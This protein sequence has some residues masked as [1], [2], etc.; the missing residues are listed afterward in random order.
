MPRESYDRVI[1]LFPKGKTANLYV[2]SKYTSNALFMD[3]QRCI[4]REL[5]LKKMADITI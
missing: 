3:L 2:E 4:K 5:S 1:S